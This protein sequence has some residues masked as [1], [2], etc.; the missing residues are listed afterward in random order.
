MFGDGCVRAF[1]MA[2]MQPALD[3]HSIKCKYS[4]EDISMGPFVI[5]VLIKL[6][7]QFMERQSLVASSATHL[8]MH[9]QRV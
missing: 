7:S 8:H 9:I 2:V 4:F 1:R 5:D 6:F 3:W